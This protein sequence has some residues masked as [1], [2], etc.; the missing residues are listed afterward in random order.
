MSASWGAPRSLGFRFAADEFARIIREKDA[1]AMAYYESMSVD[2]VTTIE[3]V[4]ASSRSGQ[5][6][7]VPTR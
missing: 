5:T 7:P 2:I 1:N 3:A 6:E 4:A